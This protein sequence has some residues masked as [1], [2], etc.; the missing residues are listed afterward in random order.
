MSNN[1]SKKKNQVQPKKARAT[2]AGNEKLIKA[3]GAAEAKAYTEEKAERKRSLAAILAGQ[4]GLSDEVHEVDSNVKL[5]DQNAQARHEEDL[6]T[7][8][9]VYRSIQKRAKDYHE[10]EMSVLQELS[11]SADDSVSVG[12]VVLLILSCIVAAVAVLISTA[13]AGLAVWQIVV[14]TIATICAVAGAIVLFTDIIARI[15]K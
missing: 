13:S 5:A 3:L 4:K 7:Q 10:E 2:V 14:L 12:W 15:R 9:R 1:N 8:K 11:E 6:E